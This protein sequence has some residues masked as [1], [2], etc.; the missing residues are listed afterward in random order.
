[1]RT[2]VSRQWLY[3]FGEALEAIRAAAPAEPAGLVP[4]GQRA[5]LASRKRRVET[6]TDDNRRLRERVEELE[7]RL[8]SVYGV[9]RSART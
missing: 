6:L 5:S 3:K 1:M 4:Q 9:M 8:V 2:A 7:G